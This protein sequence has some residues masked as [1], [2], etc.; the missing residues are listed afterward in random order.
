MLV[1]VKQVKS[2][3]RVCEH[4]EAFTAEREVNAML[5]LVKSESYRIESKFLEPVCG[6][7]NFLIKI[8]ERKVETVKKDFKKNTDRWVIIHIQ[9]TV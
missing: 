2:K 5:D 9:K 6:D 8:L 7:G 4:A 3:Q 1:V